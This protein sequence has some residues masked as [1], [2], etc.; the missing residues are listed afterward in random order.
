MGHPDFRVEQHVRHML[1]L[2]HP[3]APQRGA[4]CQRGVDTGA[5]LDIVPR[6]RN[7][8][9]AVGKDMALGMFNMYIYNNITT[10]SIMH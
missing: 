7:S 9:A 8:C 2:H 6:W 1:K 10:T 3:K 4:R 5:W